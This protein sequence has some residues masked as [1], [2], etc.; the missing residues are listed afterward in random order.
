MVAVS[1]TSVAAGLGVAAAAAACYDSAY[2]LQALEA[3]RV[4]SS[5]VP[6]VSVLAALARR[7]R[8][9][10]AT[11]LSV[12]GGGLQILAL[13]LAPLTLVQPTLALG[14]L[15]LLVLA[16]RWL[17]EEVGRREIAGALAIVAGV[18]AIAAAAPERTTAVASSGRL[19]VAFGLLAA[20]VLAPYAARAGR[21]MPALVLVVGAGAGDA[22]GALAAKLISDELD[23]GRWW[24][25]LAWGAGA[26]CALLLGLASEMTA[27]QR[28]PATRVAPGVLVLQ[29]VVP[30]ALAPLLVGESWSSTPLGGVLLVLA[31]AVVAAG[32]WLLAGSRAVG[33]LVTGGHAGAAPHASENSG[34]R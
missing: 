1:G 34:G 29:I 7:P 9:V 16:R 25:A 17:G 23:R 20:I 21:R 10:A 33:D 13:T 14:L 8:W 26:G 31:L 5:D 32:T 11:A 30:V 4:R 19:A 27:L 6:R 15:L 3:R 2:A 22:W 12:G 24:A 18:A 28:L